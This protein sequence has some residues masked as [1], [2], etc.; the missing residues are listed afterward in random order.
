[1]ITDS[2]RSKVITISTFEASMVFLQIFE[3]W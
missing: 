2:L 1:M 3:L